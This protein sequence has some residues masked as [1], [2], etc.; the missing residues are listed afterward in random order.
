MGLH[1]S[2]ATSVTSMPVTRAMQKQM[3]IIRT[4]LALLEGTFTFDRF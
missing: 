2:G 3:G 4:Q 1:E